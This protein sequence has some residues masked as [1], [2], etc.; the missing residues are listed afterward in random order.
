MLPG[1]GKNCMRKVT[2]FVLHLN[3]EYVLNSVIIYYQSVEL[4][5][6]VLVI[7]NVIAFMINFFFD[8]NIKFLFSTQTCQCVLMPL[9]LL[10][11]FYC[12]NDKYL[13]KIT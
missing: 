13:I 8:I 3:V 1:L 2:K 4:F 6:L 11:F 7:L 12:A 5:S 9:I 10:L